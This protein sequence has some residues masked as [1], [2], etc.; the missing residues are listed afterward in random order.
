MRLQIVLLQYVCQT[1]NTGA[2]EMAETAAHNDAKDIVEANQDYC[3]QLVSPKA[4]ASSASHFRALVERI[5]IK[6]SGPKIPPYWRTLDCTLK[7]SQI[8]KTWLCQTE[9]R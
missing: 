8:N 9:G 3:R 7:K 2:D 4:G 1:C 6:E 5:G